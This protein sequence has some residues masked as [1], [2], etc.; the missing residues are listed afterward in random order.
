MEKRLYRSRIN[1][2]IGGVCGGLAEYFGVDPTLVRLIAVAL[3]LVHGVGLITYIIAWIIMPKQPLI[4]EEQKTMPNENPT[5]SSAPSS[6]KHFILGL[7]LIVIGMI[8]LMANFYWW[9]PARFFVPICLVFL[10]IYFLVR[11][12]KKHQSQE[13]HSQPGGI[14]P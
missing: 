6:A 14:K 5:A 12:E 7:I 10:G 3:F 4:A 11:A 9:F 13:N 1:S 8:F 2:K